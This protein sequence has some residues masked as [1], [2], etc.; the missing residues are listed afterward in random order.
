[1]LILYVAMKHDY[2]RPEQGYSHEHCNF[3][4]SL[5]RMGHDVI[6]FDFLGLLQVHGREEMNRRLVEVAKKRKPHLMFTLLHQDELDPGAVREISAQPDTVTVNWF[7]DDHFRFDTF[8]RQ[9]APCFNWAVTTSPG[10]VAKYQQAGY[11][12]V[13]RS[14]WACN[15]FLYTRLD[16]PL[17]HDVTFIGQAHGRRRETVEA[18][19][20][21]G[22]KIGVWGSGW[23][24][25]RLSQ[26]AMVR[27]FNQSRINLNFSEGAGWRPSWGERLRLEFLRHLGLLWGGQQVKATARFLLGWLASKGRAAAAETAPSEK[28]F[29]KQVK[30]RNFEVPGCGGFLLTGLGEG[31][32]ECYRL[33]KEVVCFESQDELLSKLN[34]YL[35]REDERAAIAEAGFQR[36]LREHTYERRFN[37]IFRR[38]GFA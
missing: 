27:V 11:R 19:R 14:Q 18:I 1:M 32:E 38:I 20:A 22:F 30:A 29:P 26:E 21:A 17:E 23:E 35:S 7:S 15:H 6:Y 28:S 37:E 12:N 5:W 34:Y 36:T 31:L 2:G 8:S 33:G 10:A 3:F 25:G 4:D 13:I 16:L 9:W 24:A